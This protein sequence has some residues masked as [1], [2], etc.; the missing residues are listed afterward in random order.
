[1]DSFTQ[2]LGRTKRKGQIMIDMY[3]GQD[4]EIVAFTHYGLKRKCGLFGV[5]ESDAKL[6][7]R[8][9]AVMRNAGAAYRA[10][11]RIEPPRLVILACVVVACIFA[12]LV[13][14]MLTGCGGTVDASGAPTPDVY[15]LADCS[16]EPNNT[17]LCGAATVLSCQ[18]GHAEAPI[19]A[20]ASASADGSV[21]CCDES[22][23]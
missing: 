9:H 15:G 22:K 23:W 12:A 6:R 17:A 16:V 5:R 7:A 20:C 1:M 3:R 2:M 18:H 14:T 21:W 13:A 11:L 19:N 8:C 4:L 10:P